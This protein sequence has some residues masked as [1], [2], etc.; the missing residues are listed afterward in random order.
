MRSRLVFCPQ[1]ARL[2][3]LPEGAPE[4]SDGVRLVELDPGGEGDM[5][6]RMDQIDWAWAYQRYQEAVYAAGEGLEAQPHELTGTQV[7]DVR[8][9]GVFEQAPSLIQGARWC[10]PALVDA[11]GPEW[12]ARGPVV[13]YCVHGHEVSRATALR[14]R[15]LGVPARFLAGGIEAWT[16]A[17]R[18]V[19]PR[20]PG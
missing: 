4:P 6:T 3:N 2:A 11:W 15:A 17:G 19:S 8:R 14:L 18:P 20:S 9:S 10:D 12:V 16:G 5:Q 13:V 7:L 1:D